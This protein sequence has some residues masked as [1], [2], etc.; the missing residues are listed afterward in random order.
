[1]FAYICKTLIA[2]G[3]LCLAIP[4]VA[5]A[6]TI[7]VDNR[8]TPTWPSHWASNDL[9]HVQI[10]YVKNGTS[11][12]T[13]G[14]PV[15]NPNT[16]SGSHDVVVSN[17]SIPLSG[18]T[19]IVFSTDGD[20]NF[21]IDEVLVYDDSSAVYYHY[22]QDDMDGFCLSQDP[23]DYTGIAECIGGYDELHLSF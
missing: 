8:G 19:K 21:V 18:V 1:M 6:W 2:L 4:N 13:V 9:I 20:D 14:T 5:M 17:A 7:R 22:E 10:Y 16:I 11:F 3:I 23:A 12:V 15:P